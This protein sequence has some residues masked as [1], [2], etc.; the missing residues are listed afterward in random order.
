MIIL[1]SVISL[2]AE[3]GVKISFL[4]GLYMVSEKLALIVLG[5]SVIKFIAEVQIAR[6]QNRKMQELFSEGEKL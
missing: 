1:N 2:L 6:E 3:L 5:L 4:I